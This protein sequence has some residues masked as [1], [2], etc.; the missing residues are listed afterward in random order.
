M[1][2]LD[3]TNTA[4]GWSYKPGV[5]L[6]S[7]CTRPKSALGNLGPSGGIFFV[8]SS[9][10]TVLEQDGTFRDTNPAQA[11]GQHSVAVRLVNFFFLLL[12]ILL[13]ICF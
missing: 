3:P 10:P 7:H 13:Y 6:P 11:M 4:A 1:Q 9:G 5:E 8:C 2:W 12:N